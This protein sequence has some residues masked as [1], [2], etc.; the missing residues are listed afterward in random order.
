MRPDKGRCGEMEGGK[1][2]KAQNQTKEN[3]GSNGGNGGSKKIFLKTQSEAL[4]LGTFKGQRGSSDGHRKL[5][6]VSLEVQQGKKDPSACC[7]LLSG[8]LK[9]S[10]SY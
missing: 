1:E 7:K 3:E 6:V 8:S 10:Q 4:L 5:G 9:K 2:F